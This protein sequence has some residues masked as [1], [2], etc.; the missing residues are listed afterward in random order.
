MKPDFEIFGEQK[1]CFVLYANF[2][3][4]DVSISHCISLI[5]EMKKNRGYKMTPKS[6]CSVLHDI[7]NEH[8]SGQVTI[9]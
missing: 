1:V 7:V 6:T 9:R 5:F 3:T 2:L 8:I 4:A